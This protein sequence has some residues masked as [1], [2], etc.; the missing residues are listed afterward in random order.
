[1]FPHRQFMFTWL[2][3]PFCHSNLF[4]QT[5]DENLS[6]GD[7][8]ALSQWVSGVSKSQ[9]SLAEAPMSVYVVDQRELQNW[10]IQ[11]LYEIMQRVLPS[12]KP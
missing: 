10:G 12:L 1:M 3:F 7:I 8:F 9:E 5:E 2:F 11:G 4:A 6:L